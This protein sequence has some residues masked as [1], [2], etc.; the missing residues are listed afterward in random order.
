MRCSDLRAHIEAVTKVYPKVVYLCFM[1]TSCQG[2][3]CR[4]EMGS[5]CVCLCEVL[6]C[7]R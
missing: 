3:V 1:Q 4:C 2:C 5:L 6:G 7:V